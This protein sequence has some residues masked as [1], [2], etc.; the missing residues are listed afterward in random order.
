MGWPPRDGTEL[1]LAETNASITLPYGASRMSSIGRCEW[2]GSSM[3]DELRD[4]IRE[5][6]A[7]YSRLQKED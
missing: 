2:R 1:E 5:G 4:A 3:V 7:I 6:R